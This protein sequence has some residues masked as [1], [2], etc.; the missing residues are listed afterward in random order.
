MLRK[1]RNNV[2]EQELETVIKAWFRAAGDRDGGR[3]RRRN[4]KNLK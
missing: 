1:T 4:G 3:E 2:T